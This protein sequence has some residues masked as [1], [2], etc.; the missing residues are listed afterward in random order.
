VPIRCI[1]AWCQLIQLQFA[2]YVDEPNSLL[3]WSFNSGPSNENNVPAINYYKCL[4]CD[5]PVDQRSSVAAT[6]ICDSVIY[7][8]YY[9]I[10]RTLRAS[11]WPGISQDY[12]Q[13]S[14]VTSQGCK[15]AEDS[16]NDDPCGLSVDEIAVKALRLSSFQQVAGYIIRGSAASSTCFC[17]T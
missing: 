4:T 13:W 10:L 7:N 11:K 12:G 9:S 5:L 17:A 8:Y 6:H 2:A 3:V 15:E 1:D 14:T 16:D